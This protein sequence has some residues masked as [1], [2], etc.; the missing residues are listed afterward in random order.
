MEVTIRTLYN[1]GDRVMVDVWYADRQ[2]GEKATV[3]GIGVE[4]ECIYYRVKVDYDNMVLRVYARDLC[5]L[6]ES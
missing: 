4:D 5:R 1:V 2:R 3:L 6:F